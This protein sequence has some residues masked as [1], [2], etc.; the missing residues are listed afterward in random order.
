VLLQDDALLSMLDQLAT[1]E[2]LSLAEMSKSPRFIAQILQSQ[3][4]QL[5]EEENVLKTEFALLYVLY[6]W[7]AHNISLD[8]YGGE[9]T[10][11][12]AVLETGR[13]VSQGVCVFIYFSLL[14]RIYSDLFG[15][16]SN[17]VNF[18]LPFFC[19]HY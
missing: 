2:D 12:N 13:A 18:F 15:H 7:I 14:F 9:D 17:L 1:D 16:L 19:M 11:L 5:L 10:S 8:V 6:R 4:L 3:L